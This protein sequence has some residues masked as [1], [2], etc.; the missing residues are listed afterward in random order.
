MRFG[1]AGILSLLLLLAGCGAEASV[2]VLPD[3]V[4]DQL[5]AGAKDGV[6]VTVLKSGT[7]GERTVITYSIENRRAE[8]IGYG[9][10][11]A[12]EKLEPDGWHGVIYSDA[13]FYRN[14]GFR[15][16]G[17]V[18]A[19]GGKKTQQLDTAE[20]GV[21]LVPGRYRVVKTAVADGS[22]GMEIS[23]ASEFGIGE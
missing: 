13:V 9:G 17:Q 22:S 16:F 18:L 8:P 23:V 6:A 2:A 3:P 4:P 12:L 5:M 15:D 7:G 11:A 14:P 21:N 20:L 19:P 10:Y 1:W